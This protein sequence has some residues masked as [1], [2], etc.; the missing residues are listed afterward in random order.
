MYIVHFRGL[1]CWASYSLNYPDCLGI[2]V[3]SSKS[4]GYFGI[5]FP[6]W[7][8]VHQGDIISPIIFNIVVAVVQEWY[9]RMRDDKMQMLFYANDSCLVGT[10]PVIVQ[11]SLT[12]IVDLF[13]CLN[14]QLNAN[15][16][17][18]M[19]MFAHA[20]SR[21][22]SLEAYTH[23]FN[24]SL[25]THRERSLQKVS[26]PQCNKC[27]NHQHLPI[28]QHEAHAIPL[29][30]VPTIS[31]QDSNKTYHVNIPTQA[32]RISCPVP[33]CPYSGTT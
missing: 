22:E 30:H 21:Q 3:G 28:H 16:T 24:Q 1:R 6:A 18:V 12:L 17:K 20:A 32:N 15:K 2:G 11:Q 23:H 14:L 25:P 4:G 13:H 8:G 19:I 9:F 29:L 33:N 7:H 26:C 5:P 27:M 31:L 10:D